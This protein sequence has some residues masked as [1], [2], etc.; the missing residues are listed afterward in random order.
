MKKSKPWR[1]LALSA[2]LSASLL[3]GSVAWSQESAANGATTASR[4]QQEYQVLQS[5]PDRLLLQLSN[6]MLVIVQELRTAPVVTAQVWV[7]TGSIYEQEHVGAGLSHFLEHLLSGGSTST[8]SEE[9]NNHLLGQIGAQT[10]AA[11]GL[12]NVHYY[13]NTTAP[14]AST[15]VDLLSDWMQNSV[16][17]QEEYERERQVI[18]RE[19]EHGEGSPERLFWKLTQ[20]ARFQVHPARH[21]TIGYLDEFLKVTRDEIY[22]FYRRMYVPNNMVFVVVGDVDKQAIADQITRLWANAKPGKLPELSLPLEPVATSPR[23]L[24]GEAAI[25]Q[26]RMRLAWP[27]TRLAEEHD[28]ALDLLALILGGGESSR[29]PRIVRDQ[30]GAVNAIDAYNLSFSWG[31]GFFGIDSTISLPPLEK[32]ASLT[33][34]QERQRISQAVANARTQILEQVHLI[35]QEDVTPEELARA[36][37]LQMAGLVYRSQTAQ[38]LASRMARDLIGMGDPDYS[39]RYVEAIESLT[40]QDLQNAARAMLADERLMTITLLP[41]TSSEAT[42]PLTRPADPQVTFSSEPVNLDNAAIATRYA[43]LR[44]SARQQNSAIVL[45]PLRRY[46]LSNGLRVLI[47]RSTQIPAVSIQMYQLGGLLGETPGQEGVANATAAMLM[48]GTTTRS[49][50]EIAT[51]IEDLGATIDPACGNNTFYVSALALRDD[52]KAVLDLMADVT[53][54]PSFPQDEWSRMQSRLLAAIERQNDSWGNELRSRFRMAYFGPDYPWSQTPLGRRE[55]V[56]SL[57]PEKLAEYHFDRLSASQSV[58]VIVGD[59]NPQEALAEVAKHFG[60]MPTHARVPFEVHLP[61]EPQAGVYEYNTRKPMVAVQ[62]GYGP[63]PDRKHPD[64]AGMAVLSKVLSNFP[65]GWLEQELRGRG[66]GLVYAVGA[67]QVSGIVPG[68]LTALF[69]TQATTAVEAVERS[70]KVIAR[71]RE[72]EVD[73]QTLERAKAAV[74]TS[75][76]MSKQSNGDLA[77]D[78]A[79]NELYELGDDASRQFEMQVRNMTAGYLQHVARKYLQRP[80][81]VVISN[82]PLDGDKLIQ[83]AQLGS[84]GELE[85]KASQT[86]SAEET[87]SMP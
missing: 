36:K 28:Y 85:L 87:T 70:A 68:Y 64:F 69:N 20:Q 65:T 78:A 63:G 9:E 5:R 31:Q 47:R 59:V 52:W 18:Q 61:P 26:P 49:A 53:L 42:A 23:E 33:P 57:T 75:E 11:T 3:G 10:N 45:E 67:G 6:G 66:P 44:P 58:V 73:Q 2:G 27:G 80:V 34:E 14:Y 74:L 17:K 84:T 35:A 81:V 22:A 8:R 1:M 60:Q 62:F 82:Q 13:I 72:T 40:A 37:R 46:V 48:R 7:K 21:P 56:A 30:K 24:S 86:Q 50:Q 16:I 25:Q 43:Q 79:L 12:D 54:N 38:G 19:F 51:Q 83:A 32:D 15:A 39:S 41:R 77:T 71:L 4:P 29:L 76:F 55:V